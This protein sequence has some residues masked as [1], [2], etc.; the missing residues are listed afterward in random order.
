[1]EFFDEDD[2]QRA[3]EDHD[4]VEVD[5]LVDAPLEAV[6]ALV[7]EPGWWVND[8]PVGDHECWVDDEGLHHVSD[9]EAGE[10]LVQRA[11][12]DPMDLAAFRWYPLAGD[13][14]PE[15]RTT[16]VEVSLSEERGR[17]AVHVE[18]SGLSG[19]SEDEDEARTAWEDARGLWEDAL[20]QIKQSLEGR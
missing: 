16:R 7:S 12:S 10:W 4:V 11:E 18:E 5:A 9:P 14:F 19:V 1:M 2:V 15:D 3:Q 6:W 13:E 8:G 17:V 20:V